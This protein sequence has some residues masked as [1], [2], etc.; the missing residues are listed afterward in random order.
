MYDPPVE[1]AREAL[2]GLECAGYEVVIFSTRDPEQ[3]K[4][5]FADW[6]WPYRRVTNVKEPAVA[7]I[8]DRAIRFEG[9]GKAQAD[10]LRLYPVQQ[11]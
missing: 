3:I 11:G 5:A 1:G 8:D 9:W 2:A 6:H 4:D 7:I 10:V